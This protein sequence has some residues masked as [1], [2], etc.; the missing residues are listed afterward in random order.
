MSE[1]W[2]EYLEKMRELE[3]QVKLVV[4]HSLEAARLTEKAADYSLLAAFHARE[5]LK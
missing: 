5:A 2:D 3:V 4:Y 1:P